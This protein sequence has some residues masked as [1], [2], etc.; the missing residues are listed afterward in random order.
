[1]VPFPSAWVG[2]SWKVSWI[3]MLSADGWG[4]G[5]DDIIN[6]F[7]GWIITFAEKEFSPW[8]SKSRSYEI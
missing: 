8:I 3:N 5:S 1:M 4:F 2:M 7:L 6:F